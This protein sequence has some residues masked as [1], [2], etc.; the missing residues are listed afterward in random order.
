V[1]SRATAL[2]LTLPALA[3]RGPHDPE[4]LT[5]SDIADLRDLTG[6]WAWQHGSD[7]DGVHR[8]EDERWSF[9]ADLPWPEV[10]G[11]YQ[12]TVELTATDGVPFTCA[13]ATRYRLASSVAVAV[14][15]AAGGATLTETSYQVAP[16]PCDRGLRRLA[17][18]RARWLDRDSLRLDWDDGTAT[19]R[20]A[21]PPPPPPPRAEPT[22]PAG[23]WRWSARSWTAGRLVQV[24]DERWELTVGPDGEAGGHYRRTVTVRDPDGAIVPCAGAPGYQFVDRYLVRGRPRGE[25]LYLREVAVA[26]GDHPC[27]AGAPSRALDE[28]RVEVIGDHLILTWRG[29]RRQVLTR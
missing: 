8:H 29:N 11:Q 12:R 7:V 5:L 27:L 13:Q 6:T 4:A 22:P 3:C 17:T 19:L 10:R 20:R 16:S 18:Y 1:I 28:A 21:D 26:A 9:T 15:P 23:A 2:A 14:T 24:E 25:A